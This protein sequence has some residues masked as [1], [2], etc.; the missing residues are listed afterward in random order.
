MNNHKGSQEEAETVYNMVKP[1]KIPSQVYFFKI[2]FILY[3]DIHV[4]NSFL[5]SELCHRYFSKTLLI[6]SE[7]PTNSF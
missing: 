1:K 2:L 4:Q 6:D 7:L 5:K 3:L